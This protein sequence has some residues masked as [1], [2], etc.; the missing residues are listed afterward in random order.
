M[1]V[2]RH[3]ARFRGQGA[4]SLGVREKECG[5]GEEG[6][7]LRTTSGDKVMIGPKI[8]SF[9]LPQPL[10]ATGSALPFQSE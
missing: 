1:V 9:R 10:F 2:G 8:L 3:G 4:S 6:F 7:M 5:R